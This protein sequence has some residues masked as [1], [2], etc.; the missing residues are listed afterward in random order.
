MC[1]GGD[2]CYVVGRGRGWVGMWVEVDRYKNNVSACLPLSLSAGTDS[3]CLAASVGSPDSRF[4]TV[5]K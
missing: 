2:S 3:S 1:I 5:G 4:S